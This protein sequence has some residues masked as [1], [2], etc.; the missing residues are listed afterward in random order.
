MWTVLTVKSEI[1]QA[2]ERFEAAFRLGKSVRAKIGYRGGSW[3]YDVYWSA[4]LGI[5]FYF[6]DAD[7]RY[8]NVFGQGQPTPGANLS[9][10]CQINFPF[11]GINRTIAGAFAKDDK[12]GGLIVVHRGK[13]GG[14]K[15][16]IGKRLFW[17]YYRGQ[18]VQVNDDRRNT[19]MALVGDLKSPTF[20]Y[21]VRDFVFESA[22]IKES[23]P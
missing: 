5:W 6:G 12:P 2:Q 13:L 22:R 11:E 17:Q 1:Q 9:I 18:S 15:V 23:T 20:A 10:A 3:D 19:R 14:G 16:G 7:N 8:W 4:Q 21:K